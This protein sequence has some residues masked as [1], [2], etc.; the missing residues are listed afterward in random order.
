MRSL[1]LSVMGEEHRQ[2]LSI[3]EYKLFL[4]ALN[5]TRIT[6][7]TKGHRETARDHMAYTQQLLMVDHY[8]LSSS[9]YSAASK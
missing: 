7:D 2:L 8:L 1:G 3:N 4:T 9:L 6:K 5:Y